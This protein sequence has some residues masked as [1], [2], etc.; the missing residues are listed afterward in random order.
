[1]SS[2]NPEKKPEKKASNT[3]RVSGGG[4]GGGGRGG[5]SSG[6]GGGGGG[7][8][9]GTRSG[10]GTGAKGGKGGRGGK[11][12]KGGGGGKGRGGRGGKGGF[13]DELA[14][15]RLV[16]TV[17]RI[18]RCATV[19]KGG[20][21]FSFSALVVVGDEKGR[22]GV[23]YGKAKGVPDAVEKGVREARANMVKIPLVDGTIPHEVV[24]IFGS[25]KV[26]LMPASPGTGVIAGATVR[27]VVE[28]AGIHNIL[29]KSLGSPNPVNL[30]KATMQGLRSLRTR[31]SVEKLRGVRLGK[32]AG[33]W[34]HKAG[35]VAI[36][37][38]EKAAAA[39]GAKGENR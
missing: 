3:A 15:E 16:E 23:G 39:A 26:V 27:S 33:T 35:P 29:T 34:K 32:T 7:R 14:R 4:G 28:G 10:P 8:Q 19:V 9:A 12:G 21:R 31:Q 6:G 13:R 36:A 22:I 24:G 2:E 37:K 30:V 17:V 5:R 20:R 11:G 1:M 38:A 25:S 18:N